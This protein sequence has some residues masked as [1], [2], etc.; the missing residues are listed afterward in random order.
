MEPALVEFLLQLPA[1]AADIAARST[2]G[3]ALNEHTCRG[4]QRKMDSI[5]MDISVRTDIPIEVFRACKQFIAW[6]RVPIQ[7]YLMA[8]FA[9]YIQ[10]DA[11]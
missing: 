7:S 5:W 6:D 11:Q 3:V 1:L 10:R 8:E 2:N 9:E 4:L